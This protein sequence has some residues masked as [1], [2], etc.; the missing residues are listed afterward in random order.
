M[1]PAGAPILYACHFAGDASEQFDRLA[2]VLAHTARQHCNGWDIRVERISPAP[3]RALDGTVA[4]ERNTQK[5]DAWVDV[6]HALPD[7][8]QLLLIDADTMILRTLNDVW[9]RDFDIAY[10]VRPSSCRLP[11]N[12]GVLFVRVNDRSRAFLTA[13]R[14]ENRRM[15]AD[16]TYHL[17]WRRKF[18]GINQAAL[19]ATLQHHAAG[20]MLDRL[21]CHEWNCEDSTWTAFDP[22]VTRILHI[23]SALR[24]GVFATG[25]VR[26]PVKALVGLWRRVEKDAVR[27]QHADTAHRQTA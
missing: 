23:K 10:T 15:L 25:I 22:A 7:G 26:P 1:I 19:G 2:R 5:L 18:G 8:A 11:L 3:C 9:Q 20:V 24:M 13:W 14:V 6:M 4:Y 12:A 16:R 17:Q 21:P 27:A